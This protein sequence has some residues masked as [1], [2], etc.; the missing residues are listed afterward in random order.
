MKRVRSVPRMP[1]VGSGRP[2]TRRH[3]TEIGMVEKLQ[4]RFDNLLARGTWM[5]V[6]WLLAVTLALAALAAFVFSLFHLHTPTGRSTSFAE[7]FWQ[8]L[9]RI[10]D[11]GTMAGDEAWPLRFVALFVTLS[12]LFLASALIGLIV[13]GI[14]RRLTLLRRGRSTVIEDGHLLV[15]GWSPLILTIVQELLLG[16][17]ERGGGCVVVLA[18]RDKQLMEDEIRA[19]VP[20]VGRNRIV[21]RTGDPSS[22]ADLA[23]A[24]PTSARSVVI[25]SDDSAHDAA[26]VKTVLAVLNAAG[27][28]TDPPPMVVEVTNAATAEYLEVA[29][30]PIVHPVRSDEVISSVMAQTC[31]QPGLSTVLYDLLN[32]DGDE[33]HMASVPELVGHTF[34]DALLS[35]ERASIVGRR[36]AD[37]RIDLVPPMGTR[38][39]PGD[40]VVAIAETDRDIVFT[41]RVTASPRREDAPAHRPALPHRVLVV[42]WNRLGR[43]MMETFGRALAPGSVVSI[44]YDADLADPRL[45]SCTPMDH[46][47]VEFKPL[48]EGARSLPDLVRDAAPDRVFVLGYRELLES[49]DADAHTLL[50]LLVVDRAFAALDNRPLVV[51]ELVHL[52]DLELASMTQADDFVVTD[53]L[54]GLLMAQVAERPELDAVFHDLLGADGPTIELHE[55]GWYGAFS[56]ATFGDIVD[57]VSAEGDLAIGYRRRSTPSES[58][59]VLNPAKSAPVALEAE[60]E[61]IVLA[62]AAERVA[63]PDIEAIIASR[64]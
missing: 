34:G 2:V 1:M 6:V 25:V 20:D 42:G 22:P 56:P 61:V 13:S 21:C 47:T 52:R 29:C 10:I 39:E 55:L 49:S 24:R 60:D 26:V 32:F 7:S 4:Y 58:P 36:R 15:L 28:G 51:A 27:D 33:L 8:S 53:I 64:R 59:V 14:Y 16:E 17:S 40:E 50:S 48:E 57:R 44:V 63:I 45:C 31:R 19:S 5:I 12:G 35:F 23:I 3:A 41:G 54:S 30:G 62:R 18:Q 11:T 9:L 43:L 46:V 38:F 37:G